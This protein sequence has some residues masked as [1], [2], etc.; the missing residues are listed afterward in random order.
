MFET[1]GVKGLYIGVQATLALY[2]QICGPGSEID[3]TNARPEDLTGCVIDSGDGVTHVFPVASGFVI[4][5]CV[6]HIPLAGRDITK[7]VMGMLKDRQEPIPSEDVLEVSR[8][9][10]EK[11]GYVCKDLVA[12]YKKYDKKDKKDD[13]KYY[14]PNKFKKHTFVASKGGQ[15]ME[16]DVG[17]ERFLG[18][19]MF[20]HPV[21]KTLYTINYKHFHMFLLFIGIHSPITQRTT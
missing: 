15:K 19:E 10:K 16:C 14:L 7:F 11:Y 9:V 12:E 21:S 8:S 6:K 13:G 5:S 3:L 1:F 18:P 17:Y 4:G 2:S 20:F